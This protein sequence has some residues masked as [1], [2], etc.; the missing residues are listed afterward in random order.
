MSFRNRNVVVLGLGITGLS[1]ARWAARQGSRVRVADTRAAPPCAAQLAVE[2]PKVPI[3]TGAFNDATFSGADLVVISPGLAKDHPAVAAAVMRGVEIVGDVELFSRALRPGQKLLAV[4]GSNGKTTV[5]ALAGELVRSAGLDVSVIGNIGEPVLDA[6]AAYEDGVAWPDVFVVEL[7]SFQLETTS[8]LRPTAAAML[9]VTEN[10]LDRYADISAYAAAKAR[11]FAGG[12]EQILNRDDPRSIA[13][14]LPGRAVQTF[15]RGVPEAEGDWGIVSRNNA[16]WLARGGALLLP[17]GELALVGAHNGQNALAALALTSTIAKIDSKVLVA[18]AT[19]RGLP[20]RMERVAEIGGVVF[21]NDSKG[22][23]VAATLAALDGIHRPTV[24]IAG[25]EGK[26][27][28]FVPLK[29]SV[30]VHCRAV[31]LIGRDAPVISAA[32]SGVSASIEFAPALE[33]AVARAI[34][35]ARRGDAVLL[36]PACA[37]LDMFRDY[38]ERGERFKAAVAAHM[39]EGAHA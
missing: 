12:G 17:A 32:L 15:G 6:L 34:S 9:N 35:L 22:T 38:R 33:V 2:L 18:L 14:R 7:S 29:A 5:S 19:F 20:H 26:G 1:A 27:Q 31:V 16:P 21:V 3:A 11:I 23:T 10:H 24:L 4:T 36:S 30:D 25:G 39:R 37:S 8:S 13:M 28:D